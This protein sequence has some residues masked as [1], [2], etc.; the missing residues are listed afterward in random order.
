[1]NSIS[2]H[3]FWQKLV[4]GKM[5]S[6]SKPPIK[7]KVDGKGTALRDGRARAHATLDRVLFL[8]GPNMFPKTE[9]STQNFT[10]GKNSPVWK[11]Y[12]C[13]FKKKK[14]KENYMFTVHSDWLYYSIFIHK[15]SFII[16]LSFMFMVPY[17]SLFI[18]VYSLLWSDLCSWLVSFLQ[19]HPLPSFSSLPC[20]V[21]GRSGFRSF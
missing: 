6:D 19:N 8:C 7:T 2:V 14:R 10:C 21:L 9:P 20:F 18:H 13:F 5:R 1:M 16:V 3:I 15:W 11:T 12:F 4:T 17:Y